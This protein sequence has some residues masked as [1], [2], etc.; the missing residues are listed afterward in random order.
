MRLRFKLDENL[1][2]DAE[3]LLRSG[4][5][6]VDTVLN[7]KLGGTIDSLILHACIAERRVLVTLDLDFADIRRYPPKSHSGIGVLRPARQ[8]ARTII[9]LLGGAMKLVATEG[10]DRRPWVIDAE[11]VRIRE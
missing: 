9:A 6:D 3:G 10:I 11:R 5:H 2:R 8:N 4:G 1:P 7:E